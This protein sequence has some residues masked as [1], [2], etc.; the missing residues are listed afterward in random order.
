MFCRVCGFRACVWESYSTSRIFGYGYESVT[1]LPEVPGI[2]ARAYRTHFSY[3]NDIP[4]PR[5]LVTLAHRTSR[6]SGYGYECP[7]K[8]T[9]V[10]C[11]VLLGVNTPGMV[12]RY[13]TEHNLYIFTHRLH[14]CALL[15]GQPIAADW[16]V[17]VSW[18]SGLQGA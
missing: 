16:L 13:P 7:T 4:V 17:A 9:K 8:L 10:L 5:V 18:Y 15:L 14:M 3:K 12:C 6:S 11:T 1:E 2:V